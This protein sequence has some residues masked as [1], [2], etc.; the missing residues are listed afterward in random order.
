MEAEHAMAAAQAGADF[1]GMVFAPSRR[2]ITPEKVLPI[3]EAVRG[4]SAS[5]II[6]G[7][8]ADLK[9]GEVNQIA[10]YCRLDRVQLSGDETWRYCKAIER[11]VIKV[12]HVSAGKTAGPILLKIDTGYRVLTGEKLSCLLDSGAGGAYGGTGKTFD[13]QL[14]E[15]V[16]ARFPVIVAGGLTPDNVGQ[17][18]REAAPWGVDVSSGVESR[19]RKDSAKIE[20]FIRAVREA[21]RR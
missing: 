8:F 6:V 4:L 11:P 7:V 2:Q 13:W 14:A 1:L 10:D 3:V 19:G 17:L 21:E 5:P 12:I 20:A 18:V 16:A 15:E 9:A